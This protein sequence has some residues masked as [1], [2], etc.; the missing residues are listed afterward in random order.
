MKE[1]KKNITYILSFLILLNIVL[2]IVLAYIIIGTDLL[3]TKIDEKTAN[4]ISFNDS[5]NTDII[6]ITN[7]SILSDKKGISK[8]NKCTKEIEITGDKNKKFQIILYPI[9]NTIDEK[10][11]KYYIEGINDSKI[12]NLSNVETSVDNGKI[13]YS[14]KILKN[15]KYK[16]YVWIDDGYKKNVKDISYEIKIRSI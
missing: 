9:G 16:L 5:K 7:I 12:N 13:I 8:K 1:N 4:Y 10:Y 3:Q 6:K 15:N 2:I 14:D 11:V